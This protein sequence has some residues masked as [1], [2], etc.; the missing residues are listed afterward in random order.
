MNM[1]NK[2]KFL[3]TGSVIACILLNS[4]ASQAIAAVN[5]TTFGSDAESFGTWS[6]N[7]ATSNIS[8]TA[9]PGDLLYPVSA[10]G[11]DL[12]TL[13]SPNDFVFQL[14]GL[15]T[16]SPGGGFQLTLE[17]SGGNISATD[18]DFSLFGPT[19]STVQI[20]V[21]TASLP[22]AMDWAN[23]SN[24][25]LISS[26]GG[27]IDATFTNLDVAAVPEPSTYALLALSGLAF[28][29]YVIRRRRRA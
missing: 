11:W 12:S 3:A 13:G 26:V 2:S 15:V 19:S 25:N 6:Y 29:G 5:L 9:A 28:G 20:A 1:N 8:G 23:I 27:T 14:T 4:L 7:P 10:T 24:W 21:N 17:D 22:G 18:V 16:T